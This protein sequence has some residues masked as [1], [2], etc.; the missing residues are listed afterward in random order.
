M[1]V[2]SIGF[3]VRYYLCSFFRKAF[4]L[5]ACLT[6]TSTERLKT[7]FFYS[8][9]LHVSVIQIPLR[10]FTT[11]ISS[12]HFRAND[13]ATTCSPRIRPLWSAFPGT[14]KTS[15]G[16]IV[17]VSHPTVISIFHFLLLILTR[18]L[19]SI[20][21]M[22]R[23]RIEF[24]VSNRSPQ[25]DRSMKSIRFSNDRRYFMKS[26]TERTRVAVFSFG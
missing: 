3:S 25:N 22:R 17:Q 2:Y 10:V 11:K 9:P 7:T 4:Q 14:R 16:P 13:T 1:S 21:P 6:N 23:S 18:N 19:P 24:S 5:R 15:P 8:D 20:L 12:H 26:L